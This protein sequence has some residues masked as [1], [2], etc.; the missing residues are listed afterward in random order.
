MTASSVM[1]GTIES[2]SLMKGI[3][4]EGPDAYE[5]MEELPLADA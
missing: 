4:N 3:P 5:V 2:I 1:E